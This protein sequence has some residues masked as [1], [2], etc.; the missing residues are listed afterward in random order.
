MELFDLRK[1]SEGKLLV[2]YRERE[3]IY[4]GYL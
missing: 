4:L 1:Q 2:L 3:G